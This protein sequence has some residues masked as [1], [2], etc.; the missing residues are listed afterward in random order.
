[1]QEKHFLQQK[2]RAGKKQ[3]TAA[4]IPY[5]ERECLT[6]AAYNYQSED[7]YC[8]DIWRAWDQQCEKDLTDACFEAEAEV[9]GVAAWAP[10]PTCAFMTRDNDQV[11]RDSWD[12]FSDWC[13]TALKKE[14]FDRT[15]K[16]VFDTIE[17]LVDDA[18]VMRKT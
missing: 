6:K 12:A 17:E 7:D 9:W 14:E 13:M 4:V 15:C 18:A 2:K 16:P 5:I 3:Q 8:N 10:P 1:M 11:C